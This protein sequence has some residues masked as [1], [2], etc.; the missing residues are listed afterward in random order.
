MK[1][2]KLL[3]DLPTWKAWEEFFLKEDGHLYGIDNWKEIMVYNSKTLEK[4]N[5]LNNKEWMKEFKKTAWDLKY[6]DRFYIIYKYN[7]CE[8]CVKDDKYFEPEYIEPW[9][10]FLTLDEANK[11][12]RKRK[13]IHKIKKYCHENNIELSNT[14]QEEGT[15]LSITYLYDKFDWNE[16]GSNGNVLWYF[17]R[18]DDAKQIINTFKDDLKI[19]FNVD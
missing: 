12:L 4:F 17:K 3:K 16:N 14:Y 10:V 6:W 5:I 19:I 7:I 1:K 11:E 15:D 13:A 18:W 8:E 2:Y 9:H